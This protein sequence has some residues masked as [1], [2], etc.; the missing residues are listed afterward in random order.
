MPDQKLDMHYWDDVPPMNSMLG[1][2]IF[3]F[4]QVLDASELE[5]SL[6]KLIGMDGWCRFGGDLRKEVC[7]SLFI[8][9]YAYFSPLSQPTGEFYLLVP[10]YFNKYR[11][12]VQFT[13]EHHNMLMKDHAIG[14]QFPKAGSHPS[15]HP[16]PE[17]LRSLTVHKDSPRSMLRHLRK[18][19]PLIHLHVVTFVDATVVSLLWPHVMCDCVG[20]ATILKSWS[21]I[22]AGRGHNVPKFIGY[23]RDAMRNVGKS[24]MPAE[25]VLARRLTGL[26]GLKAKVDRIGRSLWFLPDK[27]ET[28]IFC[29]PAE[30]LQKIYGAAVSGIPNQFYLAEDDVIT[31]W[32]TKILCRRM[33]G[34]SRVVAICKFFDS[35]PLLP[36][37]FSKDGVY[38]QNASFPYVTKIPAQAIFSSP[39]SNIA[40]DIR[41]AFTEQARR[42]QVLPLAALM[43]ED[44]DAKKIG[45]IPLIDKLDAHPVVFINWNKANLWSAVDFTNAILPSSQVDDDDDAI[46]PEVLARP[47]HF[48]TDILGLHDLSPHE[49]FAMH[50]K[51]P[52]GNFWMSASL[53][54]ES[55][56][57]FEAEFERIAKKK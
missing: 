57:C 44:I 16:G 20:W 31:A 14:S 25:S 40:K 48:H 28:R 4:G 55:M 33:S 49:V 45:K 35:R 41:V 12:S 17:A 42:E 2:M 27:K 29:L 15:M 37:V 46:R 7:P 9:G 23:D 52:K 26:A 39:I 36:E 47:V 10:Q 50:G 32:A 19:N 21:S 24:H 6:K 13:E 18:T 30:F 22:V 11:P 5:R 3:V 38:V 56:A 1:S 43:R 34:S 53:R 51:D 54:R 8:R